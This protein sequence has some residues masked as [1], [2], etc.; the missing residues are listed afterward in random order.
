MTSLA[1][2]HV[3]RTELKPL[4]ECGNDF[5]SKANFSRERANV[6]RKQCLMSTGIC[7]FIL[8]LVALTANNNGRR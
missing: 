8:H 6:V 5:E 7:N 4:V 3:R 1:I 2:K